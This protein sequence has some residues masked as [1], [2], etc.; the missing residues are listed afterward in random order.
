MGGIRELEKNIFSRVSHL[1][2][3]LT[4]EKCIIDK[5]DKLTSLSSSVPSE[6]VCR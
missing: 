2:M 3:S 6:N 1:S 5:F 4:T